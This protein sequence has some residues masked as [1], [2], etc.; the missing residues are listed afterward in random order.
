MAGSWLLKVLVLLTPTIA[1]AGEEP[2]QPER[3]RAAIDRGVAFLKSHQED[4]TWE[5]LNPTFSKILPGGQSCLAVHALLQAGIK[6]DDPT[7][8]P[9]LDYI[10]RL[11]SRQTYVLALQTLVLARVHGRGDRKLV[12]RNVTWLQEG[13]VWE[14]DRFLGW[15]YQRIKGPIADNSNTEYA[16]QALHAARALDITL[17]ADFWKTIQSYYRRSQRP[18]GGWCYVARLNPQSTLSMTAGG[19]CGLIIASRELRESGKNPDRSL[20]RAEERLANLLPVTDKDY[21]YYTLN[22]VAR[23]G[24]MLNQRVLVGKQPRRRHDWYEEG[25]RFVLTQQGPDGSWKTAKGSEKE[26]LVATSFA[27]LFLT[28]GSEE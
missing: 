3:V 7:L 6:P 24:R 23:A 16:I 15:S 22:N 28:Q 25:C 8:A 26:P 13:R 9:A 2:V 1:P 4:G 19:V 5:A 10:R 21:P 14:N 12:Q 27:L 11:Q 18:D 20:A 17:D